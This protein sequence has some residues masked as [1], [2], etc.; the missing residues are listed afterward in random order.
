M[1]EVQTLEAIFAIIREKGEFQ[2]PAH[3]QMGGIWSTDTWKMPGFSY[4]IA[5]LADDGSTQIVVEL[6]AQA[7]STYGRGVQY[8]MAGSK[9]WLDGLYDRLTT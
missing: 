7:S 8:G 9:K 1:T 6:E 3:A 2:K 5:R 4:L